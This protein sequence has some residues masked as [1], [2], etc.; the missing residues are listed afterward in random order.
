MPDIVCQCGRVHLAIRVM[1]L[2]CRCGAVNWGGDKPPTPPEKRKL[3]PPT[4]RT[5]AVVLV[6][7]VGCGC[8][9]L[10]WR[11]WD[12]LGLDWCREH[13]GEIAARLAREPNA[14]LDSER[15]AE[16]VRLAIEIASRQAGDGQQANQAGPSE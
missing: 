6:E 7:L 4:P 3:P 2:R 9:R 1:P 13:A 11:K 12:R 5:F 8:Q 15:A 14:G 10:P 16:L